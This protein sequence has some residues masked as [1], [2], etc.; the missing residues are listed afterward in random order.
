MME[1]ISFDKALR[2]R[3]IAVLAGAVPLFLWRW[4]SGGVWPDVCM[5]AYLQSAFVFGILL[6]SSYPP[7]GSA[8][9]GKSMIFVLLIHIVVQIALAK[10]AFSLAAVDVKLPTKMFFGFVGVAITGEGYL[11]LRIFRAFEPRRGS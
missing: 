3:L 9:F 6:F 7:I 10:L 5:A 8:W 4:H 11:A 2:L 1:K